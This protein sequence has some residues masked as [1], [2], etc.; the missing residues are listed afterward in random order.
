MRC[1]TLIICVCVCV[2][3]HVCVQSCLT[4]FNPM[5]CSRPG[6]SVHGKTCP[7]KNTEAGCHFLLQGIFPA[8][9]SNL[10][11][12]CFLHQ[13]ADY[14]VLAQPGKLP[15]IVREMQIKT[16][17]RYYLTLFKWATIKKSTHKKCWRGCGKKE[18]FLHNWW[19]CKLVQ[20]LENSVEV[21]QKTQSGVAMWS[22]NPIPGHISREN[23]N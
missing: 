4:L 20:P 9:E 22:C 8:Q 11:L 1:S 7:G 23:S 10:P 2:H 3:A 17:M 14:S 15:L 13:Q 19:E 21:P 16:T 6:S 18:T 5:D 12:L